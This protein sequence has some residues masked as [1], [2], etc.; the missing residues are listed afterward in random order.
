MTKKGSSLIKTGLNVK[1]EMSMA[2]VG[3]RKMLYNTKPLKIKKIVEDPVSKV[4]CWVQT[5]FYIV[6]N[7][8]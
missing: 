5:M 3:H 1:D 7:V 6:I 8:T 4:R 2:E